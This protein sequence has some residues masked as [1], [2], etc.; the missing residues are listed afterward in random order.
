MKHAM[1]MQAE[2][3]G[4]LPV[5][6][7]SNRCAPSGAGSMPAVRKIDFIMLY[8]KCIFQQGI[9]G[10][11]KLHALDSSLE[12][13]MKV[14]LMLYCM[15]SF[16]H[17]SLQLILAAEDC[18]I[19][20]HSKAL[21]SNCR[22]CSLMPNSTYQSAEG[23]PA[24]T[25]LSKKW[26]SAQLIPGHVVSKIAHKRLAM[27]QHYRL[28]IGLEGQAHNGAA[29]HNM[30]SMRQIHHSDGVRHAGQEGQVYGHDCWGGPAMCDQILQLHQSIQPR[31][32][33]ASS[34]LVS[35]T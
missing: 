21:A 10:I 16:A 29:H 24:L 2:N 8:I 33:H 5:P 12:P 1:C 27:A 35:Y 14:M 22:T 15:P 4:L 25:M 6:A 30:A 3:I 17:S 34:A 23:A 11:C 9:A 31:Q 18:C 13:H 20:A 28:Q 32:L 26:T 19:P 7:S